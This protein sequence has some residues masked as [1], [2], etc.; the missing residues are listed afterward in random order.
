[1]AQIFIPPLIARPAST[2]A[3]KAEFNV[4]T[5]V[6]PAVNQ[7]APIRDDSGWLAY[8]KKF[9]SKALDAVG[10]EY[11]RNKVNWWAAR[12][13]QLRSMKIP[14]SL[15]S[16]RKALLSRAATIKA[17][18]ESILGKVPSLQNIGLGVAP[19]VV[20][21]AAVAVVVSMIS[22]WAFDYS[23]FLTRVEAAQVM[24][25][26]GQMTA[27]QAADFIGGG[28]GESGGIFPG[29]FGWANKLILPAALLGL[30]YFAFKAVNRGN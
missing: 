27:D 3:K 14:A 21:V 12:V 28:Q 13:N 16:E 4:Y 11:F 15:E 2:E 18:V 30:G 6:M 29:V 25:D 26:K 19:A 17:R 23:K 8:A 24:V 20:A 7:T 1:M 22:A 10:L 9:A 5:S